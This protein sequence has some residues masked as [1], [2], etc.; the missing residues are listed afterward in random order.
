MMP[1]WFSRDFGPTR[2]A[3]GTQE[4]MDTAIE[5][6]AF[7]LTYGITDPAV[8]LGSPPSEEHPQHRRDW[9]QDLDRRLA[10][11]RE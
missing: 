9:Y 7:R 8:A 10:T 6:F 3:D 2:P 11:L 1:D 5:V 4:W